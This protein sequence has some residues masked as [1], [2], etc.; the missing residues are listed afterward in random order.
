MMRVIGVRDRY[1][2]WITKCRCGLCERDT[3]F[4]EILGGL[5]LVPFENQPQFFLPSLVFKL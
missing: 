2:Q 3:M 5:L 1:G 4:P